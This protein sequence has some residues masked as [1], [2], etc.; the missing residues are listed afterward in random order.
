VA[1]R[2]APNISLLSGCPRTHDLSVYIFHF[3]SFL[4]FNTWSQ[5]TFCHG[6]VV[7]SS[8]LTVFE[9]L[10]C[11]TDMYNISCTVNSQ[12][13]GTSF[14]LILCE[15]TATSSS[16]FLCKRFANNICVNQ[17]G[18]PFMKPLVA[19]HNIWCRNPGI[20]GFRSSGTVCLLQK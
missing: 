10:I 13:G 7:F 1:R 20:Q 16:I 8:G 5:K 14:F 9:G 17:D 19:T 2:L 12:Y 4:I 3:H 11:N 18:V 6:V 15:C